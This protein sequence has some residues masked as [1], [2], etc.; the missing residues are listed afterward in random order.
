MCEDLWNKEKKLGY[1]VT[2]TEHKIEGRPHH[3]ITEEVL[4]ENDPT[5]FM[6]FFFFC[7]L[8]DRKKFDNQVETFEVIYILEHKG[9]QFQFMRQT[10]KKILMIK[11]RELVYVRV[12]KMLENGDWLYI[13]KSYDD[14]NFEKTKKHDRCFIPKSGILFET[15]GKS[16]DWK[17]SA[18][19]SLISLD[20]SYIENATLRKMTRY[21][22]MDPATKIP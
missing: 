9:F 18:S 11:G 5:D 4:I 22:F 1:K 6:N 8:A 3:E 13:I 10:T 14:K 16:V 21:T 12:G 2:L 17:L 20:K 15:C 7:D 19:T